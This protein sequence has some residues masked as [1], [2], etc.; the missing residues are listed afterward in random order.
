M[1]LGVLM[2]SDAAVH[3]IAMAAVAV[4]LIIAWMRSV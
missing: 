3:D 4:A 2:I 1:V